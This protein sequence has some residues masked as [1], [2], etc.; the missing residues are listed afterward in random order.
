[1][2]SNSRIDATVSGQGKEIVELGIQMKELAINMERVKSS[3]VD[4][5]FSSI[6]DI[7]PVK[8]LEEFSTIDSRIINDPQFRTIIVSNSGIL[9]I[10][11]GNEHL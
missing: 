7:F 11:D 5:D 4:C 9:H 8:S 1:M 2:H 10:Y 3:Q 6:A